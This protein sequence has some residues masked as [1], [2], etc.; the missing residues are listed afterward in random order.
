MS[1]IT[2]NKLVRD[3]IPDIILQDGHS[4]EISH[5]D[6]DEY[7]R[8]LKSKLLEEAHEVQDAVSREHLVL[9]LADVVE[10]LRA[11]ASASEIPMEELEETRLSRARERGAF[12]GRIYLKYVDE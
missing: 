11:I 10:V 8:E 12:L 2:Y 6:N 5:L 9:E 4:C 7:M 1:R 3:K